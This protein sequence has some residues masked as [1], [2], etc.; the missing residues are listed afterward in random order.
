M[1]AKVTL[2]ITRGALSGK[3]Y[4]FDERTT[5][6]IGRSSD[7]DPKLPD[8]EHHAMISRYH[9]LLDINPPD[10]RVRDFGSMNGTFVNG[11]K[12]GQRERCMTPE[13]GAKMEFL[14]CDLKDSDEIEVGDTTFRVGIFAPIAC[15]QCG[16][17]IQNAEIAAYERAPNAYVCSGCRSTI[18]SDGQAKGL[19]PKVKKC[20]Q[21]GK[22]VAGEI[23]P[24]RHGVFVCAACRNDPRQILN[25]LFGDTNEL[26]QIIPTAQGYSLVQEL[27]RGAMGLVYLARNDATGN[28]IAIKVMLPEVAFDDR[29]KEA[30]QR[31]IRNIEA[32]KHPNIVA[33]FDSGSSHGTFFVML[34]YCDGGSVG[35]L[36]KDRGGKLP[37][38][39]TIEII[40]QVLDGL[41]YAHS[42]DIPCYKLADGRFVRGRGLVHRDLKPANILL[43]GS[44]STRTAKIGDFGLSKA[45]DWAGLSGYTRTG[46]S[47]GTPHFMPRQSV[48]DFKYAQP[49]VDV[50]AVAATFYYMVTGC[51]PREFS[52]DKD[53]WKVILE[54]P[55][56]P[57]RKRDSSVPKKLA[58]IIDYALDDQV[59]IGVKAASELKQALENVL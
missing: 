45:F 34:E 16:V 48:I 57:I 19:A 18:T 17:E 36:V 24:Y 4:V 46:P 22:D 27:G 43:S 44:G 47:A 13:E 6:I 2:S 20:V 10:I 28:K 41:A 29:M 26:S 50:W 11:R 31:E 7:C 9:C 12:I 21:C 15:T 53:P 8:D 54:S 58:E 33:M 25:W 51:I 42:A 5:C 49:E 23:G 39:E 52:R 3:S 37:I 1:P 56:V 40:L 38:D 30:F 35:D 32:L 14:E 55:P 59:E